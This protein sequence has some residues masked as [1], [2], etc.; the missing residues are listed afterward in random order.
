MQEGQKVTV[1]KVQLSNNISCLDSGLSHGAATAAVLVRPGHISPTIHCLE[2]HSSSAA[3]NR[4]NAS[5][6]RWS[7]TA[8]QSC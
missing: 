4:T 3:T 1:I 8:K 6:R 5:Y 7:A 2:W